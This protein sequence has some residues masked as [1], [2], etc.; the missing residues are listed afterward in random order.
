MFLKRLDIIGFKSFADRIS[1]DFVRGVTAVVGPNGSGKSNITDAI[2]WV[3]GEQSA[4]SLRGSKMEDIIFSGSDTRK[5]L[6]I[7]E[8]TLTLD[9]QDQGLAIDYNEVSVTRRVSRSGDSEFSINKQPCRLKDIIDLFMDSGLGREAFSIISQGKV[10]EILNSKAEDRRTIFEEAAGVLKYKNRKKKAE[11]KLFETQDNLN[12]VNDIL[13]ELESQVEPLKIQASMAKDFLEKKEALE[14]IEVALTVYEVEDLHKKWENLSNQLEE[15]QEEELKLSTLLQVKEA[16]IV[17]TRDQIAAIDESIT[18]LQNVLLF[19]SEELE[20]LEGRKEVLKERKKNAAQNKEQLK[21]N[22]SDLTERIS[23]LKKT[24]EM[25]AE[26]VK[27]LG[28]QVKVLQASLKEKQEKLL[29]FSENIDEKIESLKS[30]YIELLNEQAGAKNEV[31]YIEQQLEQQERKNARLDAENEKYLQE[32]QLAQSKKVEIQSGLEA[33]QEKLANQ[34]VTFREQQRKLETVKDNYQKQEKTLYQAYQLLQQ[35]KSRKEMLEELEE[36]YSGFFQ[37]VKEVLKARGNK[38]KGIEGAVA[39]LVTVPKKYEAA[40]ETAFGGALQHIVV[41]NEQNARSAIQFLK[42]NSFGRAT[43]LPLNVMKGRPLSPAQLSSIQNHPALIGPAV[44]LVKFEQKYVEVINNLL[45]NVVITSDLKGANE[46]AKILQYRVRLVTLDGDIVNPGGSMTGGAVKQKTSSLLSRKGE[47]EDLKAKLVIMEEKTAGLE[48]IVKS[49]KEEVQIAEA[50]LEE[51]RKNGEELRLNEQ[52]I[53]GD[54]REAE[55]GEKNINDRLA[56]YDLEKGQLIDEQA[57]LLKRKLELREALETY[58]GTIAQL[59]GQ[60]IKL[61][62]Q[63]TNDLTSKE[64]LTSE[65]NDLKVE[66]ASKNEQF[67]HTK[68]RFTLIKND[69]DESEQKLADY[70]EDLNLLTSE[71]TNSSSGEEQLEAAAITKQQDKEATLQLITARRQERLQLQGALE[72]TELEAKE[73]KRLHKGMI[74]GLKDEEVKINRLDVEL[75]NRLAH[76]REEYLLSFEGAKEQYPLTI[77]P[78]EAKRKVK[79]I[80]LAIDELGSV[81]LGAIEE[82]DRVSERYQFLNEQKTDLQEAKDTLHQVI[83]EMDTE[84]KKRFEQTFTGIR[85]Y[86]EPTFRALFGGGKADLVLTV[87]EDLLNTGVEIVAQPPGKKLQNLGLL[88]GGE[89]ALTA[90]ALLFSILKVRPVPFCILDEV[91]AALDEANVQRFSQYLKRYS[92]ETQFI[93]ITHRKGTMEEADVLYGVTM[94]ESGVS[95]LVSVRLEDT[96]ELVET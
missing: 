39:E 31:K 82:Y 1:V 56:I 83:E 28:G 79:L 89:R 43:F 93:V 62:E 81:N 72:D 59:D 80:K 37:G 77:P 87:P 16:K 30:E 92:E 88:S 52:A 6:N 14:K 32:R 96:K 7:A 94:K 68:E 47:L 90:I 75:E 49:L 44:S 55:L 91:E 2:R 54:L 58:T 86:F 48:Q 23:K 73:L 65:I 5:A 51:I 34:V 4:K 17:E 18:D 74:V 42:Q 35:A 13:H 78:E 45:G 84:M 24:Q 71:M 67:L 20:K 53:K 26:S 46:L 19:A 64:T 33:S 15:H 29:L 85:G 40:L 10:E 76:L 12:R 3:L 95:K 8:V 61:T 66:F 50:R 25:H 9:N 27:D 69:L 70:S 38:L 60:I 36:D 57:A 22:I 11:L 41:D 63:K 21:T